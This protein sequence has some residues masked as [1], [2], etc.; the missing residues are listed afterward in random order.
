MITK[1]CEYALRAAVYLAS[2]PGQPS[3]SQCIAE[4]TRVPAGYLSKVLQAMVRAGVVV[5]QRG[6]AGGF[7]LARDPEEVTVLEVVEAVGPV[8][9]A[10][11]ESVEVVEG[12][13]LEALHGHLDAIVSAASRAMGSTTL[14]DLLEAPA[15][16]GRQATAP[17]IGTPNGGA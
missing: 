3:T 4:A 15:A 10:G 6:P 8:E 2:L 5:S 7:M 1:T 11:S 17:S 16:R 9:R 12:G 13:V 14:R